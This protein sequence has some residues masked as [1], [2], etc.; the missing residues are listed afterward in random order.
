MWEKIYIDKILCKLFFCQLK[1]YIKK[2]LESI[3]AYECKQQHEYI[4]PPLPPII[5]VFI[6]VAR[7]AKFKLSL[8]A[9]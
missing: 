5:I 7:Y 2:N 6:F 1:I 9:I 4:L 3:F 8:K